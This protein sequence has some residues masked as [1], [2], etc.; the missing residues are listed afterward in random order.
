MRL[1]LKNIDYVKIYLREGK[2]YHGIVKLKNNTFIPAFEEGEYI[3][4]GEEYHV[5]KTVFK[6]MCETWPERT[7]CGNSYSTLKY[8]RGV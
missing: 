4:A 3:D 6:F 5:R 8:R 7:E 2:V 1:A